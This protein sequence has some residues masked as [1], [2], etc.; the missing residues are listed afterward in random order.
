MAQPYELYLADALGGPARPHFR[1]VAWPHGSD[2]LFKDLRINFFSEK[3]RRGDIRERADRTGN[4]GRVQAVGRRIVSARGSVA[5][6]P[7]RATAK[8]IKSNL[9]E[10]F[11]VAAAWEIRRASPRAKRTR[12]AV[13]FCALGLRPPQHIPITLFRIMGVCW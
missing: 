6:R 9:G 3:S 1:R 12:T 4:A 10:L 7:G 2:N 8:K 5:R 11:K 13:I